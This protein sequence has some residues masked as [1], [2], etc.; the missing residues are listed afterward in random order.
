MTTLERALADAT[1]AL[2]A[3]GVEYA[4][5]GGLALALHGYVRATTDVDVL[6]LPE[7]AK[8]A[9][10]AVYNAGFILSAGIIPFNVGKATRADVLRVSR[11]EGEDLIPLDLILVSESLRQVWE[12]RGRVRWRAAELS[13]VSRDGLIQMKRQ[14]ARPSDAVDVQR[15]LEIEQ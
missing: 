10:A 11:A 15:L 8:R 12:T 7:D 5:C 9:E 3:A 6:I 1:Q 2:D 14:S 13:I 4:L